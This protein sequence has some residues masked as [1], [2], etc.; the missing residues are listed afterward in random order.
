MVRQKIAGGEPKLATEDVVSIL[1]QRRPS[2]TDR[3]LA[4][5]ESFV[6]QYGERK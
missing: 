4:E 2:L 3:D 5:Y 1:S 6:E